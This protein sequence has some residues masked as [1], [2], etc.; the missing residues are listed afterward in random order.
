MRDGGA[1]TMKGCRPLTD[2]ELALVHKSFGGTYA[3][4][5]RAL[6][7]LG[8]KS[9]FR[10]SELL[11]LRVGDVYQQG[12]VVDRVTVPRRHMKRKMEGR[13]V[14]LHPEAKTALAAWLQ[15]L[16][17]QVPTTPAL[18]VFRSRKGQNRPIG[19]TYAWAILHAIYQ[20]NGFTGALG[21][22]AM[23]KTFA[24]RVYNHLN[25]DLVKTQRA[26]GHKN[27]NSTVSYLSFR[28]EE[29]DAAIL[30]G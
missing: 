5:D 22:H 13:T 4:R 17:R 26:L 3:A 28:D 7:I 19:R 12:R 29:I 11:S 23:R 18:Y 14:L 2:G 15:V 10:I 8:V 16:H 1:D 21:T 25:H 30:A 20:S 9:G 24:T 6:F 27:I